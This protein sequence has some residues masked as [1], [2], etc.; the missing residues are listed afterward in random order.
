MKRIVI[1]TI[2][3]MLTTGSIAQQAGYGYPPGYV[4]GPNLTVGN[5]EFA[6][7]P[8]AL[9]PVKAYIIQ[10]TPMYV[11]PNQTIINNTVYYGTRPAAKKK[12]LH[13]P[14]PKPACTAPQQ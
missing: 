14:R 11:P 4:P 7:G 10:R 6:D 9:Y 13:K 5:Q 1:A 2:A 12:V 8:N 3:S